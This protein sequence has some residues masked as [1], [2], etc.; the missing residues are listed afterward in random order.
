MQRTFISYFAKIS[1]FRTN[2][3]WKLQHRT[4]V[5]WGEIHCYC[6]LFLLLYSATFYNNRKCVTV[7]SFI[8]FRNCNIVHKK[9]DFSV[10]L[11]FTLSFC[12]S[13]LTSTDRQ[14]NELCTVSLNLTD[15]WTH[16]LKILHRICPALDT[17][18]HWSIWVSFCSTFCTQ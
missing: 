4:S 11:S 7:A 12:F 1:N 17:H 9:V 10:F 2:R 18:A 13:N 5:A 15:V 16:D 8:R 6:S 14:I 3:D